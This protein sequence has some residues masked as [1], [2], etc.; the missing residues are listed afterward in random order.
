MGGVNPNSTELILWLT[1]H[2]IMKAGIETACT[3][4]SGK[5]Q[6]MNLMIFLTT[7]YL[8]THH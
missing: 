6:K 3:I 1:K 5:K 2:H 7:F 4:F 8:N